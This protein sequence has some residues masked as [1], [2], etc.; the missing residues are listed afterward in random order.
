MSINVI[1][2]EYQLNQLA[3][4][5]LESHT[6]A[7]PILEDEGLLAPAYDYCTAIT[8]EHSRTFYLAASLLPKPE[9][10][11]AHAL[12]AFC[13]IS[14]DLVDQ[15]EHNRAYRLQQWRRNSL[16][17]RPPASEPVAL[18]WADTKAAYHIPCRYAE[19]LL[20]GIA[21]DLSKTRYETFAELVQYCYN[22]AS[23]V[24]LMTMHIIGYT[25]P[26]AIPY[27]IKLGVALQ[28]T[29]IL[30][31]VK[32]DWDKGRL[33]LPQDELAAFNLTEADIAAGRVDQR[34]T[35]FMQFQIDRARQLYH[36]AM[37][38]IGL[39][40]RKGR[41]AITSAALLYR[42]ILNDIE[43]HNYNVFERRAHTTPSQKL[44][45]LPTIWWHTQT[46]Q[47]AVG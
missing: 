38:G 21:T 22:V 12:Y 35:K 3:H 13:R 8:R 14:D 36:E 24:G 26:E 2:W 6:P 10:L 33:Y 34:W 32:E 44:R 29:N 23:T 5:A 20:D 7:E 30:R 16:V 28:L 18:A 37:P 41:F 43:A 45:Q 40:N 31:D 17:E 47:L 25:G 27:A 9:R 39:L 4:T 46:S 42:A 15:G 1:S 19:Q 11:A